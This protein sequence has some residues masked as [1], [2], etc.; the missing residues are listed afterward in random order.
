M[1]D[2]R[3]SFIISE[4]ESVVESI[5]ESQGNIQ[6]PINLDAYVRQLGFTVAIGTFANNDVSG[7]LDKISKHIYL[8]SE[9]SKNRRLFT[10]AHEIGHILL[11]EK[12]TGEITRKKDLSSFSGV[13]LELEKEANLFAISLILPEKYILEYWNNEFVIKYNK[14]TAEDAS[15]YFSSSLEAMKWRLHNLGLLMKND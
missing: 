3:K 14:N 10:L 13:N 9:E 4:A 7:I 5:F 8:N 11:H 1:D 12:L 15:V 2:D 6:F